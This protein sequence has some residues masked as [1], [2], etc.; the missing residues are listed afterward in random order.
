MEITTHPPASIIVRAALAAGLI[1]AVLLFSG[2][3]V[4]ASG[5]PDDPV[6]NVQPA[7]IDQVAASAVRLDMSPAWVS[8][9]TGIVKL[10]W[11]DVDGDGDLDLAA[12]G[13]DT[14]VY[15]NN[16]GM[17]LS[18]SWTGGR[19][20]RSVAWGDMDADGDLDLA[21]GFSSEPNIVYRNN[22][23]DSAGKPIL[24]AAWTAPASFKGTSVAWADMNGDARLDLAISGSQRAR[25]FLNTGANL[26]SIP[27]WQSEVS[28]QWTAVE[29]AW[30]DANRDG[31]P[32]AAVSDFFS[33]RIYV[34]QGGMLPAAASLTLGVGAAPMISSLAWGDMDGDGDQD[35]AVGGTDSADPALSVMFRNQSTGSTVVFD[36]VWTSANSAKTSGVAWGDVDGDGDL[37]LAASALSGC[38]RDCAFGE[39]F[40][41]GTF[42]YL[43]TGGNLDQ[44]PTW[45]TEGEESVSG[46][47]W[48]D[49]DGDGD[50]DLTT[51]ANLARIYPNH[52]SIRLQ[53]SQNLVGRDVRDLAWGD[54]DNDGDLDLVAT[55]IGGG[56]YYR[57][58]SVSLL[59]NTNGVLQDS[60][61]APTESAPPADLYGAS[62]ALG[63]VDGDGDLDLAQDVSNE[64][65]RLYRNDAGILTSNPVW[66]SAGTSSGKLAWVD[67]DGDGDLDLAAGS[68]V[69]RNLSGVLQSTPTSLFAE[70]AAGS[71][72]NPEAL[73]AAG[74]GRAWGDVDNDGDPDFAAGSGVYVNDGGSLSATPV[75]TPPYSAGVIAWGDVNA[76]GWL[77]LAAANSYTQI[78][79]FLNERGAFSG[80]ADW[81]SADASD[82]DH[83]V[84]GDADGDGDLD[85][86][87]GS[88]GLA[89]RDV[90]TKRLY[91]NEGGAL[92][93]AA[94]WFSDT[95][96]ADAVAWGDADNDG[97][98]DLA[99]G[100]AMW[101]MN[102]T[103]HPIRLYRGKPPVDP[104]APHR[105]LRVNIALTSDPVSTFSGGT[106]R[107]LAAADLYSSPVIRQARILP[108]Y[109]R[110]TDS[111]GAKAR[112]IRAFYSSDGGGLWRPALADPS[113]ITRDVPSGA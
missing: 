2:A 5:R 27:A 16:G 64:N 76:D 10:A 56:E 102:E 14:L 75:W 1:A 42:V 36:L 43:N 82:I 53:S 81:S 105:N 52:G 30:G 20:S 69:Y 6:P 70:A 79:I 22:G 83:L 32:D 61:W 8:S 101:E 97:C 106:T 78:D 54:L 13:T 92:N 37:D 66:R 45:S 98:M 58:P 26:D 104:N 74:G 23:L 28:S 87:A 50:L 25:V 100:A 39:Y 41:G 46:V 51:G 99:V 86:L 110:I 107:A 72:Q 71:S 63:D 73:T 80:V 113:T 62:V 31:R 35:L 48:A 77:D 67:I 88:S 44:S 109:Y 90:G 68:R 111:T 38:I 112:L 33:V 34:N 17:N 85:L 59:K 7:A 3:P 18:A 49:A 29:L 4:L 11:G 65:I 89:G 12:A 60:G 91:L 103:I 94:A 55:G 93:R 95:K 21:V 19:Y 24:E 9:E 40:S 15:L 47:A 84:W 108:I 96:A 57:G